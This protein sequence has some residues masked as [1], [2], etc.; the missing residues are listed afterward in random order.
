MDEAQLLCDV[1]TA[2]LGYDVTIAINKKD[3]TIYH[4]DRITKGGCKRYSW[5]LINSIGDDAIEAIVEDFINEFGGNE[6]D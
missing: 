2:L 4:N 5:Y 3:I 6:D 1:L